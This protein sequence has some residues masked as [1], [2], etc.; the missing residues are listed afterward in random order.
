MYMGVTSMNA[1]AS[2]LRGWIVQRVSALLLALYIVGLGYFFYTHPQLNYE[3][4]RSFFSSTAVQI[5]TV[6]VLISLVFHAW[7]GMWTIGTDYIKSTS[8]RMI[9]QFIILLAIFVFLG[10]GIKI[11]WG[12]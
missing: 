8:L 3:V 11:L 12:L 9:Y 10:W 5:S 1:K 6:L 4:W 2:G 7:I